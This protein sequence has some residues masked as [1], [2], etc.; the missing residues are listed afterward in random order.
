[1]LQPASDL[2]TVAARYLPATGNLS[3]G[4]DWYDVLSLEGGRRGVVVGDCVGHG[5]EAAVVMGQLRTASRALLLEGGGPAEVLDS[6]DRFAT[7]VDGAPCTT[8]VCAVV[9]LPA[10]PSPTPSR[11]TCRPLL[12]GARDSRW[13]EGQGLPLAV[14]GSVGPREQITTTFTPGDLLVLY[15]DGLVERRGEDIDTGLERLRRVTSARFHQTVQELADGL[16]EDLIDPEG[17]DDVAFIVKR[18]AA[19]PITAD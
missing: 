8:M 3:I 5:L 9:D 19:K 1:M 11:A 13:L 6:M 10:G 17:R 14:E 12:V 2:P 16:L 15:T 7:S 18:L 4:G